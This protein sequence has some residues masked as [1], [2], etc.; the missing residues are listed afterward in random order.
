MST[1]TQKTVAI[2]GATGGTGLASLKLALKAGHNVNVLARTPSKLA[3]LSAQYPKLN[4][5]QGDIRD[6][7][8]IKSTLTLNNRVVDVVVSAIGMV[9]ELVGLGFSS[10][11]PT[12]CEDGT[13]AILSALA[14]LEAEKTVQIPIGG[15][16]F[17]LLSTTGISDKGRDIPIAMMPMYHWML[18]VPHKD[19]KKMEE[20]MIRGEG[21]TRK[22]VMIR[23]SFLWDGESKGLGKIRTSTETPGA[24]SEKKN[25]GGVAVGYVIHREDVGLWIVEECVKGDA[26]KWHGKM[27]TLTY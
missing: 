3:D 7:A 20:T 5:I 21:R 9:I 6:I 26:S 24:V 4:V 16:E 25:A 15:P 18:N 1:P 10:K 13:K 17:V 19:K 22:W 8:S 11:D 2:F 14:Q 23:P 12:I 27:V